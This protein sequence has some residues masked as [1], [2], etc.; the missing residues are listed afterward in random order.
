MS[1]PGIHVSGTVSSLVPP[2]SL[3]FFPLTSPTSHSS[4]T[5]FSPDLKPKVRLL[6]SFQNYSKYSPFIRY[7]SLNVRLFVT[8]LRHILHLTSPVPR[9][10]PTLN[11]PRTTVG[12]LPV[13]IK[14]HSPNIIRETFQKIPKDQL[15]CVSIN[16]RFKIDTNEHLNPPH[17]KSTY[18]FPGDVLVKEE[19]LSFPVDNCTE[20]LTWVFGTTR[21]NG[22]PRLHC[23][24]R[25]VKHSEGKLVWFW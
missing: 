21:Q 24:T 13:T 23:R 16:F 18:Y 7:A 5:V 1:H 8:G 10:H 2:N 17:G 20:S 4:L 11:S 25:V 9:R 12:P 15:G 14:L 6:V 3:P 19:T 22:N